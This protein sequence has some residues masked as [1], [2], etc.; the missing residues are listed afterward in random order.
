MMFKKIFREPV[1]HFILIGTILF[2]V[3]SPEE[4]NKNQN[5]ILITTERLN[6]L[7]KNFEKKWRR[8]PGERELALL[9]D[10]F[11]KEEIFYREGL[12]LGLAEDDTIIRRRVAQK[13]QFLIED[14]NASKNPSL[15]DLKNYFI[16]NHKIFLIP[17]KR[18]FTQVYFSKDKRGKN[19]FREAKAI[20]KKGD[21]TNFGDITSLPKIY[22]LGDKSDVARELG[23]GFAK[24]LF[25]LKSNSWQG[26]I[27]SSFGF[28]LVRINEIQP[29][30]T[31]N[32]SQVADRVKQDFMDQHRCLENKKTIKKIR[33][34][35]LVKLNN[36][37]QFP[38]I[39]PEENLCQL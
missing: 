18:A 38:K 5:E 26:P 14:L 36:D 17:E 32:F 7:K 37:N 31:P 35:Y 30:R 6:Q 21:P 23:D 27:E 3:Y 22:S 25:G 4:I 28:H 15:K 19:T 8:F 2:A 1:F 34:R 39:T 20:L 33:S 29:E 12:A 13:Y 24:S 10:E 16:K 9:I 11:I